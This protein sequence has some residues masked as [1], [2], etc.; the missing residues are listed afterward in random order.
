MCNQLDPILAVLKDV[1]AAGLVFSKAERA[2]LFCAF[3][4][5]APADRTDSSSPSRAWFVTKTSL[6]LKSNLASH[7]RPE[8]SLNRVLCA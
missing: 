8:V 4:A 6:L 2:A 5:V 1:P 3:R 7:G